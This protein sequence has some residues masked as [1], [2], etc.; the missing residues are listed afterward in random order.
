MIYVIIFYNFLQIVTKFYQVRIYSFALWQK[1]RTDFGCFQ[2][3]Q[4][5]HFYGIP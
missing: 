5:R 3:S 2:D 4:S 1:N